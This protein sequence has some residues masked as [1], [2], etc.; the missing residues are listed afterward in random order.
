VQIFAFVILAGRV[1]LVM[2]AVLTGI[3]QKRMKQ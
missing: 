1:K 3:A 2:T